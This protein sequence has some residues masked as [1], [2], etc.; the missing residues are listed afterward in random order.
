LREG[1]EYVLKVFKKG[2]FLKHLQSQL[3][4]GLL[5][6]HAE[7]MRNLRSPTP[8]DF[9][10]YFCKVIH[11]IL[12]E[13]GRFAFLME[14]EHLDLRTLIERQ[15]GSRSGNDCGPF[16]KEEAQLIMYGVALGVNWLHSRGIIHRDLKASNVLVQEFKSG[17][18]KWICY[19]ADYECSVGVVGTR[20]FRAPE[21]LQACKDKMASKK[22]EVFSRAADA[23]SFG[24]ICYEILTSK[25][26]FE[27]HPLNVSI[28]T[29][30]VIN[31]HLRPEVPEYVE[32]WA[33]ELLKMCW[34]SDPIA[35]PS[36]G[37]ILDLLSTNSTGVKRSED[38]KLQKFG[39]NYR[40]WSYKGC[41][42]SNTIW[43]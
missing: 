42:S 40:N 8:E 2:T 15:M 6:I 24:M 14:K 36:F 11:G 30:L 39:Q 29:E 1:C 17:W 7:E 5:Q 37:E 31:Q 4:Q 21:I 28:L 19:V 41:P 20:F 32:N 26:P 38:R 12:L 22:P 27:D 25:L 43:M 3:P 9:P 23:Y 16:T 18:P 13:D 33:C 10:R 34:Q 35:R